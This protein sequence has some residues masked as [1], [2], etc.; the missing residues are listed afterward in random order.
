MC[1][2]ITFSVVVTAETWRVSLLS[3]VVTTFLR[4]SAIF[5]SVVVWWVYIWTSVRKEIVHLLII[6]LQTTVTADSLTVHLSLTCLCAWLLLID[7]QISALVSLHSS[8]ISRRCPFLISVSYY[9]STFIRIKLSHPSLALLIPSIRLNY[10]VN[11][12][13]TLSLV[14]DHRLDDN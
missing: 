4:N 10:V 8:A 7:N 13:V 5:I 3:I 1:L 9:N 6:L 2:H 11:W 12:Q 14:L